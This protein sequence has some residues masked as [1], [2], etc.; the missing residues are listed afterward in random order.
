MLPIRLAR[1]ALILTLLAGCR[2]EPD[3][4]PL[5]I[6][7][8]PEPAIGG[9][10][11]DNPELDEIPEAGAERLLNELFDPHNLPL[12]DPYIG[13]VYEAADQVLAGAY[14]YYGYDLEELAAA[15]QDNPLSL[16]DFKNYLELTGQSVI[17]DP[18]TGEEFDVYVWVAMDRGIEGSG[19]L[20]SRV[21]RRIPGIDSRNAMNYERNYLAALY[22]S[23]PY[24]VQE[25][26]WN[27][28]DELRL[29]YG[30]D[31][32]ATYEYLRS[33]DMMGTAGD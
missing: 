22:A 4:S 28:E 6:P 1:T 17:E 14:A 3:L 8:A 29:Q 26:R 5:V 24:Q 12:D 32:A 9:P 7:T 10:I 13:S 31:A 11:P 19:A 16:G 2:F 23:H 18:A 25:A 33:L 15:G 30:D 27:F 20:P 21:L